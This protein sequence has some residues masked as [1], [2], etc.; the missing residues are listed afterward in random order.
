MPLRSFGVSLKPG[1]PAKLT[2][3][4]DDALKKRNWTMRDISPGDGYVAALACEGSASEICFR[5]SGF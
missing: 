1:E 2:F 5:D 4:Q 3:I